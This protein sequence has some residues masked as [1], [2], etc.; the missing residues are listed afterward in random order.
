MGKIVA[1]GGGENG[2]PGTKY[3]TETFD[4]EIM[5]LS[6]KSTPN[7]LFIGFGNPTPDDYF[8]IMKSIYDSNKFHCKMDHLS[9]DD[10]KAGVG[11]EK[12]QNADI[13]YVGGG[14]TYKLMRR[15]HRYMLDV[16]LQL[17]FEQG[18][19]LCGVS[20]GANCWCS[21][22]NSI[23]PNSK[24]GE[25]M[26]VTGLGFLNVL[27]CPHSKRD[28]QRLGV[29]RNQMNRFRNL[30]AIAIDYAAIEVIDDKYRVLPLEDERYFAEKQFW[31]KN[32][33]N[34]RK[35]EKNKFFLLQE[36]YALK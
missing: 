33:Y 24:F 12:I 14:S 20:A 1:I 23:R 30:P 34:V 9:L 25:L 16:P 11:N 36:L 2:H 6:G 3:E 13:I 21:Y 28:P 19:V 31:T 4:K 29:L 15:I 10:A 22:S 27:F 32:S 5:F 7:F 18:K 26:V 35:M 17:A 8:N